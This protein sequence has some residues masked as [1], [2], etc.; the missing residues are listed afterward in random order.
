MRNQDKN[1]PRGRRK[2]ARLQ[3]RP[4]LGA[5]MREHDFVSGRLLGVTAAGLIL[6][7][8]SLFAFVFL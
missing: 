6:L 5:L 2:G 3:F 7:C 1:S 4:Q 8:S